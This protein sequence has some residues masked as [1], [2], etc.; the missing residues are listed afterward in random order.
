M[1]QPDFMAE[2]VDSTAVAAFMVAAGAGKL[3]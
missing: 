3:G 2:A 1:A